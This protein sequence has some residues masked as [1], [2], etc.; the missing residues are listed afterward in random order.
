MGPIKFI[1]ERRNWR[2]R[3]FHGFA[4]AP[5]LA[6]SPAFIVR[7]ISSFIPV[8][9]KHLALQRLECQACGTPVVGIR[10]SYMDNVICH[11]Q[12]SWAVENSPAALA[13][14]IEE[15]SDRKLSVMGRNAAR[16]ARSLYNWPRVFDEL[17]C[18]YGELR[19]KYRRS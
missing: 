15:C 17:F 3:I 7:P 13:N 12:E 10:G 8:F 4:T 2:L 19:S 5:I 14:A 11:D 1:S 18:I 16:V 9:R 6:N